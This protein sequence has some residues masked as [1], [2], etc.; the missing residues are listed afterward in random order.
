MTSLSLERILPSSRKGSGSAT[1]ASR[2]GRVV[3][4]Q[5]DVVRTSMDTAAAFERAQTPAAQ[6]AVLDRFL[7]RIGN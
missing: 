2:L 1:F 6:Q 3:S 7:A 4:Q 5:V